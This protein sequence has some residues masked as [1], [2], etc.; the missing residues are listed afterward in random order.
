MTSNPTFTA[1]INDLPISKQITFSTSPY[2]TDTGS[3]Y[4]NAFSI[5]DMIYYLRN[6]SRNLDCYNAT[7]SQWV[8]TTVLQTAFHYTASAYFNNKIYIGGAYN[9][10]N[11]F[12]LKNGLYVTINFGSNF[13]ISSDTNLLSTG[14][15]N[16]LVVTV[17]DY[18]VMIWA[19]GINYSNQGSSQYIGT[20]EVYN[21]TNPNAPNGY[22]ATPLSPGRFRMAGTSYGNIAFLGGG[23]IYSATNTQFTN[24]IELYDVVL[25]VFSSFTSSLSRA[26]MNAV[27]VGNYVLFVGGIYLTNDVMQFTTL[28]DKYDCIN[29]VWSTDAMSVARSSMA[30]SV[31]GTKAVFAGG[32]TA[33]PLFVPSSVIEVFDASVNTWYYLSLSITVPRFSMVSTTILTSSSYQHYF[34]SGYT[35]NTTTSTSTVIDT[36]QLSLCNYGYYYTSACFSCPLGKYSL[37]GGTSTCTDCAVGIKFCFEYY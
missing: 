35:Y 25:K 24:S 23:Q 2:L 17:Q 18:N 5:G 27:T 12:S 30:T 29:N 20:V 13:T 10:N 22:T 7:T 3:V 16:L 6:G 8:S 37:G 21:L 11:V 33:L 32:Y 36:L 28:V 19:G 1:C 31:S 26:D 34:A 4:D 9:P 14:R 15:R